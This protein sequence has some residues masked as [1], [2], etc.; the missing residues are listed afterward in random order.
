[1]LKITK[2]LNNNTAVVID[3]NQKEKVVVGKGI[4]YQK[5]IGDIINPSSVK[6]TYYLSS[7]TLNLKFQELLVSLPMEQLDIVEKIVDEAKLSLGK[8]ISDSIYISLSDHIHFSL[9]NHENGIHVTNALLLD[10]QRFYPDEYKIG[11]KALKIIEEETGIL[12]PDDEAGFIAL[13]IVNA[14]TEN[15]TSTKNIYKATKIIEEV[16]DIVKNYFDI[17]IDEDSLTY[18]RFINHLRFFSQRIVNGSIFKDDDKDRQ[19]LEILST[20]YDQSYQCCLNIKSFIKVTY[21]T[22]I[23]NEELLYLTIHVQRAIFKE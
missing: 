13:H 20:M 11:K 2:V 5:K 4:V 15:S 6:K 7:D 8:K 18:F 10:I 23:G 1:M 19:L 12:L 22:D 16:L 21:D 9:V 3:D 14:E 17:E